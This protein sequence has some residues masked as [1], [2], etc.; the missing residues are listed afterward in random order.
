MH[1][2]FW[3][4]QQ[5]RNTP[6]G[7]LYAVM[8]LPC[9]FPAV[10]SS[11]EYFRNDSTNRSGLT[12]SYGSLFFGI[13]RIV[14]ERFESKCICLLLTFFPL[15]RQS[16]FKSSCSKSASPCLPTS[17]SKES[18]RKPIISISPCLAQNRNFLRNRGRRSNSL[19]LLTNR[20]SCL[21]CCSAWYRWRQLYLFLRVTRCVLALMTASTKNEHIPNMAAERPCG[22]F[23][24]FFSPSCRKRYYTRFWDTGHNKH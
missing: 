13:L 6:N 8:S 23:I 7:V 20:Q 16:L 19:S 18:H 22:E 24:L 21:P 4:I 11:P 2:R 10:V 3:F 14:S 17:F 12:C 15:S 1:V 9:L 5:S